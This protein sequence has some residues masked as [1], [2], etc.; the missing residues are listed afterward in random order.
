VLG[1]LFCAAIATWLRDQARDRRLLAV[2]VALAAAN[3]VTFLTNFKEGTGLN[4]T[5]PVEAS[6]IPLAAAGTVFAVRTAPAWV[7]ALCV[8]GLAFTFAQ[9]ISLIAAPHNPIP[10]LRPFSAPAWEIVLT[11]PQFERSVAAARA[12][13]PGDP[14]GGAPLVALAAGRSLPAGQPDQFLPSHS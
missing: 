13:P 10:F 3:I 1:L 2:V 5:V 6:L 4:I 14:Y 9:S 8:T 7:P 12:C 11:R